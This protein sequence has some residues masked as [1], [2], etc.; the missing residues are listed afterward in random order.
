MGTF[1][2]CGFHS[3][4]PLMRRIRGLRKLPDGRE[5]LRGKLGLVL[6]GRAMLTS[7]LSAPD[8][9]AGHCWPTPPLETPGHSRASLGQSLV[10]SVLLY[11]GYW[12]PQVSLCALLGSVSQSCVSSGSSMVW[13]MLTSSKRAYAI[14]RSAAPRAPAPAAVHCWPVPPQETLRHSSGSVSVGFPGAQNGLFEPSEHLWWLWGLILNTISPLL[15]FCWGFPFA[16]GRGVSLCG[17][18]Q[19]F[20]VDS[21]SAVSCCF[22]VLAEDECMSFYSA[23]YT[24]K[25]PLVSLIFLKRSLVF[26]IL[27]FSSVSLHWSLRNAFLSLLAIL[28]NSAFKWVYLSFS[29]LPLASLLSYLNCGIGEDSWESFGLQGDPSSQP[30]GNQPWI[31][32]GRTDAGAETP[33]LW[34]PDE[35]N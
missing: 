19:H 20:P 3:V 10:G 27:L 11:P 5:G 34:P 30:Q 22:G 1:C 16:L 18:I 8:P 12:C 21:C 6:M 32:I 28:W 24:T 15:P 2:D 9:A 29:P 31:F 13:L 17:G 35:K 14:P 23:I 26:P 33:K 4:C 7:A 25:V